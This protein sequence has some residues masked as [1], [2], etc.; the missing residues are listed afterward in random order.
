M[1][2][3]DKK[4]AGHE[5][6]HHHHAGEHPAGHTPGYEG[7]SRVWLYAGIVFLVI[8]II[9]S[10]VLLT[11]SS[12]KPAAAGEPVA[13]AQLQFDSGN[14]ASG[15]ALGPETAK[16]V[17][18]EFADF[19]CPACGGFEPA[20]EQLRKDYVDTNKVR[21]IFF[22]MPLEQHK[23]AG[24]AAQAARCAGEQGH[25]WQMHDALYAHQAEWADKNVPTN[26]FQSYAQAV[27][28]DATKMLLC[29]EAG[30]EH[31]AVIRSSGYGDALGVRATPTFAVNGDV[32]SGSIT[33]AQL[34]GLVDAELAAG[35][36]H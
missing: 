16:V 14:D 4:Q 20:V 15:I 23:N 34:K 2:T 31:Q 1:Q 7:S 30:T 9:Y 19:Q 33:Y 13:D 11:H 24:V 10:V 18:R 8:A 6:H 29:L 32:Y 35:G 22:D 17:V 28:I 21:F 5:H 36:Q 25:Y 27:G 3:P 26:N 12:G